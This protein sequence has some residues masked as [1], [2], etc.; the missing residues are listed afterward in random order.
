V[1]QLN[2]ENELEKMNIDAEGSIFNDKG[3]SR[4]I[5][6]EVQEKWLVC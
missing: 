2:T 6:L 5:L 4:H 1:L 3:S